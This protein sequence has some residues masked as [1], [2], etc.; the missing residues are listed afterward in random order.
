MLRTG[1]NR[2][3]QQCCVRMTRLLLRPPS[4]TAS[5]ATVDANEAVPRATMTVCQLSGDHWSSP[6][7]ASMAPACVL[8]A[9]DFTRER[10]RIRSRACREN[11]YGKRQRG[12]N[13]RSCRHA[14]RRTL[15]REMRMGGAGRSRT[16]G[17]S[18]RSWAMQGI[19]SDQYSGGSDKV[20]LRRQD[21]DCACGHGWR[22]GLLQLTS[23][24]FHSRPGDRQPVFCGQPKSGQRFRRSGGLQQRRIQPG[25]KRSMAAIMAC[26]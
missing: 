18:C 25:S 20:V 12:N 16:G 13:L 15:A 2:M 8:V 6:N 17:R 1:A 7:C 3:Q 4:D 26:C 14:A 24:R 19:G 9:D 5:G 21:Q 22:A 10:S 23:S 11:C